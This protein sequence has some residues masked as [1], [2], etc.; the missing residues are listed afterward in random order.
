M[1]VNTPDALDE[2]RAK[3]ARRPPHRLVNNDALF[4]RLDPL[5]K[6][7]YGTANALKRASAGRIDP[8]RWNHMRRNYV[9]PRRSEIV[10]L[11]VLLGQPVDDLLSLV[12]LSDGDDDEEDVA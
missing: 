2:A 8:D 10:T 7:R 12:P 4:A 6:A 9:R 3:P 5:V 11:A 1:L